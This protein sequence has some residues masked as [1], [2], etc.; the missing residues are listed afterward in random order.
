M[1]HCTFLSARQCFQASS[2][3][4]TS[5][6][7][8][9]PASYDRNSRDWL[10]ELN[11]TSS[12]VGEILRIHALLNGDALIPCCYCSLVPGLVWL[13]A[14]EAQDR[15]KLKFS[16]LISAESVFLMFFSFERSWQ[17]VTDFLLLS[18]ANLL[19]LSHIFKMSEYLMEIVLSLLAI[20][21][22]AFYWLGGVSSLFDLALHIYLRYV[23]TSF[24]LKYKAIE[25]LEIHVNHCAT[26]I[27]IYFQLVH[28]VYICLACVSWQFFGSAVR[29][30]GWWIIVLT[31]SCL[32][33]FF[34][35][36][37]RY[38]GSVHSVLYH[39]CVLQN[40]SCSIIFTCTL[41]HLLHCPSFA[42][43]V[44]KAYIFTRTS[45]QLP[46]CPAYVHG[47]SF[48]HGDGRS[49]GF[50]IGLAVELYGRAP[51]LFFCHTAKGS[52]WNDF[53]F[54][55]STDGCY[56]DMV[57]RNTILNVLVA[58]LNW[59]LTVALARLKCGC[60]AFWLL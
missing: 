56:Q 22:A 45:T 19:L 42:R 59:F 10:R 32:S 13:P 44:A 58:S 54:R 46:H 33:I 49:Q 11:N 47:G 35:T 51:A 38:S 57:A 27:V 7:C 36:H 6:S 16:I 26:V 17:Q 21:I 53:S 20:S 37:L 25:G 14:D 12:A 15:E 4:L 24:V 34:L 55:L 50:R 2:K 41:S 39:E 40:Q 8:V 52:L 3:F 29:T 1:R 18:L 5:D 48:C 28:H 23:H 30:S 60:S 43:P 31:H 9:P